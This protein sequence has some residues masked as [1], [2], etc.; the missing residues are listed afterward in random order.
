MSI[1]LIVSDMDGTLLNEKL[2]VS[3]RVTHAIL[4]AQKAGVEFAIATGRSIESGSSFIKGKGI[5]APFIEL[6]GARLFDENGKIQFTRE[7]NQ[8]DLSEMLSIID[9]YK[10]HHEIIT[11]NGSYS[12]NSAKEQFEAYM[13]IF[14]DIN[15]DIGKQE[16]KDYVTEYMKQFKV[17]RVDNLNFLQDNSELQ[18]LKILFNSH[19]N[20]DIFKEIE[21]EINKKTNQLIVTSASNFNLEINHL[22]ANKGKAVA[23][24]AQMRDYKASEVITI[25]DNIN[26]LTMLDWADHSY[27][28]ANAHQ[29][30]KEK[31]SYLAPSHS[32]DAVAQIIEK[33]IQG[34][35]LE[36]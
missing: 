15:P 20:P 8:L 1:K 23:D 2:E 30:A 19:E 16:L 5:V 33:V 36:F 10:I 35:K 29:R 24:L 25:G 7:M 22:D 11:H 14:K 34:E 18:V 31:A 4:S 32:E 27:A 26:D 13:E 9:Y 3:D 28:V 21:E 6:N 12:S 17:N